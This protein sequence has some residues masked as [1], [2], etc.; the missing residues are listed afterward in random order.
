M[1]AKPILFSGPMVRALLDGR[2][3]Q[4]RRVFRVPDKARPKLRGEWEAAD[5]GGAGVT[6]GKGLPVNS[7]VCLCHGTTG[8]C[9]AAPFQ[10]GDV[11]WVRETWAVSTI[12]DT[13][14]PRDLIP[15][16]CKVNFGADDAVR[17]CKARPGIHMPRWASRLT[18]DVTAVKVERLQDISEADALAEGVEYETADPPFYYVP[19]IWPHSLTAV[20]VE[21]PGGRRAER[22]YGKLWDHINGAGAWEANPWVVAVTFKVHRV[23]VDDFIEQRGKAAA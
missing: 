16:F 1:T 14:S 19:G 21:E 18:L 22:C 10:V 11:L 4:T 13:I 3:T 20:G 2:K 8:E 7:H 9:I 23:N 5:L 15:N 12:Y 6:D 17:G